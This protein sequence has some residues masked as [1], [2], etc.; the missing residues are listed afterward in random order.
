MAKPYGSANQKLCYIQIYKILQKD[1]EYR[2]LV[3]TEPDLFKSIPLIGRETNSQPIKGFVIKPGTGIR[4]SYKGLS[5]QFLHFDYTE[6]ES[7]Y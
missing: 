4:Q 2:M 5:I 3:N 7:S 1:K 6:I